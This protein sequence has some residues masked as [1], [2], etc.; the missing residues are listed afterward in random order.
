M[1]VNSYHKISSALNTNHCKPSNQLSKCAAI[2]GLKSQSSAYLSPSSAIFNTFTG[3][4]TF[5]VKSETAPMIGI[6]RKTKSMIGFDPLLDMKELYAEER[7]SSHPLHNQQS[8]RTEI[9]TDSIEPCEKENQLPRNRSYSDH[10]CSS[11]DPLEE[12][13]SKENISSDNT[14]IGQRHRRIKSAPS[15][16]AYDVLND[17][18]NSVSRSQEIEQQSERVKPLSVCSNHQLNSAL[19]SLAKPS[20]T[21]FLTGK[22]V[23]RSSEP[24]T[25]QLEMPDLEEIIIHSRLC[26]FVE[27]YRKYDTNMNLNESLVGV[28]RLQLQTFFSVDKV[29]YLSPNLTD[30]HKPIVGS[31]LKC[32]KDVELQYHVDQLSRHSTGDDMS[33][34][35]IFQRQRQFIVCFRGTYSQQQGV[36]F[37]SK[38]SDTLIPFD[39]EESPEQVYESVIDKYM[40][41][42]FSVFQRLDNMMEQ[43]PFCDVVFTGHSFGA[44]MATLAAVRYS[45]TRPVVRVACHV[46][47]SPKVGN[48]AFRN[49][50]NSL[51]NL[52]V[53][54]VEYKNDSACC[55]PISGCH[56]GHLV[57]IN[58]S[59]RQSKFRMIESVVAYKFDDGSRRKN[60]R[61]FVSR[62]VQ[63]DMEDYVTILEAIQR[64]NISWVTD[65]AGEDGEGIRGKDNEHR[66]MA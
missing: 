11:D 57:S 47:G 19:P 14:T 52:K 56:I 5:L 30:I 34:V 29:P 59:K 65:Y 31:L 10:A 13:Y 36:F 40:D 63:R 3:S 17:T 1:Q 44:A 58:G 46:F 54:R 66:K 61:N 33:E 7:Q 49:L 20:P 25:F 15:S 53:F 18:Y 35:A 23:V 50:A 16:A 45:V 41:M 38:K 42:E 60:T 43:N 8:S 27:D 9:Q 64:D 12:M 22:E 62:N 37:K 51:P 39:R 28:P 2:S 24:S 6:Q 48:Q 21:S 55:K 32:A 4:D 26:R